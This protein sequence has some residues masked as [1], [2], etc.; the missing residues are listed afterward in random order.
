MSILSH[1]RSKGKGSESRDSS[2]RPAALPVVTAKT[3]PVPQIRGGMSRRFSAASDVSSVT[4][5]TVAPDAAPKEPNSFLSKTKDAI[6]GRS[7]SPSPSGH[8]HKSTNG[9]IDAVQTFRDNLEGELKGTKEAWLVA[10][11]SRD[12]FLGFIADE[13]L[14]LMPAKGSRWDKLLKWAEDYATKL[15]VFEREYREEISGCSQATELIFACL[16]ALLLVSR[17]TS[18][19][20]S[21]SHRGRAGG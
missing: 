18:L 8:G 4:D 21:I 16:Q 6:M 2:P 14:R 3:L 10:G 5:S 1:L 15:A 19:S 13:R 7:R 11:V 9:V 20:L 17:K 12:S